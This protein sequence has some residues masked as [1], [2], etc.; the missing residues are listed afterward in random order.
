MGYL[1]LAINFIIT[2]L[3]SI[4]GIAGYVLTS[5]G[6]QRICKRRGLSFP[7][8]SWIPVA[9][10][11]VMGNISD[12]YDGQH[13]K[14]R[15]RRTIMLV[16]S[17]LVLV[18][19]LVLTGVIGVFFFSFDALS[20]DHENVA[21]AA[22]GSIVIGILL[23]IALAVLSIVLTV[24][25]YICLY[26]IFESTKPNLAVLFLILSFFVPLAQGV[27]IF[28]CRN[29]GYDLENEKKP[30]TPYTIEEPSSF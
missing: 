26:K 11:W 3:T 20:A 25:S 18:L 8:L 21:L 2:L 15:N 6:L 19:S 17:I 14:K 13:G 7:W 10:A 29:G 23:Y 5:L 1:A 27:C 16:L 22:G 12:D 4:V 9:S 24:F 30:G 28:I